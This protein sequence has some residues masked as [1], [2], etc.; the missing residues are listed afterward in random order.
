MRKERWNYTRCLDAQP[1]FGQRF[2]LESDPN[3][4]R[5]LAADLSHHEILVRL[6]V[7]L[8]GYRESLK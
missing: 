5:S 3:E 4:E 1:V 2:D 8:D 7:R 6:R